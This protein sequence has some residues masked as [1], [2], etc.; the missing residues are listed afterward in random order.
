MWSPSGIVWWKP[1][2]IALGV[3]TAAYAAAWIF[4]GKALWDAGLSLQTGFLGWS[5]V[6]RGRR[7]DYGAF[8]T[9]GL[10]RLCRQPVYIGFALT[11]WTAPTW[12]PDQ[13][14]LALAWTAYCAVGPRFKERRYLRRYGEAFRSYQSQVPYML[15]FARAR[16]ADAAGRT[17]GR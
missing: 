1:T 12:T 6:L 14:A 5:S 11:L 10:F 16:R 8:P 4:L 15:P 3:H 17:V 9:R 13:L 7:P 2:G